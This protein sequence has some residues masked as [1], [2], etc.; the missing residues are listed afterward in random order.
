MQGTTPDD[1]GSGSP[2]RRQRLRA[3]LERAAR[4]EARRLT[5]AH[6]VEGLSLSAV[7]RGV[8]VSPP[9]LYRYFDGKRGLVLA[10]YEDVTVDFV[11]EV[12]AAAQRAAFDGVGAQ[13]YAAT[14]AV[15]D[16]AVA[17]PAEFDIIMGAG[18]ARLAASERSLDQ[19]LVRELGGLFGILFTRLREDGRLVYPAE[20]EIDPALLGQLRLYAELLGPDYPPGVALLMITCWRQIY[21]LLCMAVYRHLAATFDDCLPLFDHM[22]DDLLGRLGVSRAPE[23]VDSRRPPGRESTSRHTSTRGHDGGVQETGAADQESSMRRASSDGV[24]GSAA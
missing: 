8:G 2:T 19:V 7:A 4:A 12:A 14:R 5:A 21:G 6:G 22:L 13:L 24:P 10:V 3:E 17:N 20:E 9:A 15:L 16:W 1:S 23:S 18:Y 11:A